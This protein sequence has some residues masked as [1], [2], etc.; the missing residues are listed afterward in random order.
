MWKLKDLYFDLIGSTATYATSAKRLYNAAKEHGIQT[1][2]KEV[3]EF[4]S[5]QKSY[6]IHARTIQKLTKR[7]RVMSYGIRDLAQVDLADLRKYRY[8]NRGFQY[9]LVF[10]LV[11]SKIIKIKLIKKKTSKVV[12]DAMKE[13]LE[14]LGTPYILRLQSDK[15]SEFYGKEFRQLMKQYSI[16][17]FSTTSEDVKAQLAES[18][19]KHFHQFTERHMTAIGKKVYYNVVDHYVWLHNNRKSDQ[20][21]YKPTEVNYNNSLIVFKRLYPEILK[22][23]RRFPLRFKFA[24]GA[25]VRIAIKAHQFRHQYTS[26]YSRNLY[27]IRERLASDPV[28]YRLNDSDGNLML[29]IFYEEELIQQNE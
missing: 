8:T 27:I 11:F 14:E 24:V 23:K 29:P 28:T 17:H 2:Y 1:S 20:H 26:S 10:V 4:L 16:V 25:K 22:R 19:V 6:T 18:A 3:K 9:A 7:K 5:K 13:I 21:G 12:A 15:G